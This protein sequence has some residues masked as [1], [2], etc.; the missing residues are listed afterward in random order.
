MRYAVRVKQLAVLGDVQRASVIFRGVKRALAPSRVLARVYMYE[1]PASFGE[2]ESRELRGDGVAKTRKERD[3]ILEDYGGSS[4]RLR[5]GNVPRPCVCYATAHVASCESAAVK[6][7][8]PQPVGVPELDEAGLVLEPSIF[9]RA[10][11]ARSLDVVGDWPA[12]IYF[13]ILRAEGWHG[14]ECVDREGRYV[15]LVCGK[16][17]IEAMY[18]EDVCELRSV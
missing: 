8:V 1:V 17:P 4:L 15:V 11:D 3:V 13:Y 7:G 18:D 12:A 16:V 14:F 2:S 9:W 6:V 10:D 5:G